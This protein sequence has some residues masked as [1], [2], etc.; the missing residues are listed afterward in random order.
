LTIFF[1]N[2]PDFLLQNSDQYQYYSPFLGQTIDHI[3]L[4]IPQNRLH[5]YCKFIVNLSQNFVA[6]FIKKA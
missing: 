2:Y 4:Q 3:L 6:K 5:D 1:I